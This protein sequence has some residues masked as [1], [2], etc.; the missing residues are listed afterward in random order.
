MLQHTTPY[1]KLLQRMNLKPLDQQSKQ[2]IV[3]STF[4]MVN[5]ETND[6]GSSLSERTHLMT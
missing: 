1:E 2:N 3:T 6:S 4:K 5:T